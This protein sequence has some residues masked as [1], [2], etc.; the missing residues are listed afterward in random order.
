M[1]ENKAAVQLRTPKSLG[2]LCDTYTISHK[3]HTFFMSVTYI[4]NLIM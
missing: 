4:C 3:T 1:T 2:V